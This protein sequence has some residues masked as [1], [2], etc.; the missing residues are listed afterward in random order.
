MMLDENAARQRAEDLRTQLHRHNHLYYVLDKPEITDAEYDVLLR[1][2]QQIEKNYPQLIVPD[3]P[4]QRVGGVPLS[5][6][7]SVVHQVPMLSLSNA[8]NADELRDFHRRVL[9]ITGTGTVEYVVELKIDGLAVSLEYLDGV[10]VRGATRGDGTVGEDI[11]TNLRTLPSVPLRLQLPLSLVARGEAYMP[12]ASFL[13][14]NQEREEAGLPV[15]ANPRNAAAGS[16]RQLDPR[17]TATR[18]LQVFL[19]NLATAEPDGRMTHEASLQLM[20]QAGLPVNNQRQSFTDIERLIDY[21]LSWH[22]RRHD[23]PYEIDGLVIKVNELSLH[24]RLGTTAKSPRWAIA[25]KFPAEQ[26]HT[27]LLDIEITVGRTGTLNPTA[28]LQ[29]VTIAGSVVSRASLH[30]ADLI[31]EKDIRIGDT[32]IVQKAGDVIPE[33]VGPVT[34]LRTGQEQPFQMPDRCPECGSEAVRYPG[35]VA[36]R[37]PNASCPALLRESLIHFASRDAMDI[38][39]LGPAMVNAL[40][41]ANLVRDVADLY[42]LTQDELLQ[43]ERVGAKSADNL[44][45][46]IAAS[47]QNSVERLVLGLGIRYVGA[48][49]AESLAKHFGSLPE[50]MMADEAS[51]LA[52][53]DVGGKVATSIISYFGAETNQ[54]LINK[55]AAAGV[56]LSYI[57]T[58]PVLDY[59]GGKTFVITGTLPT[60]SREEAGK[61]IERYGGRVSGSVSKK[62]DYLLAGEKAGSKLIK[63]QELKVPIISEEELLTMLK[64]QAG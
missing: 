10:L 29:P 51:L 17:V 12:K 31:A 58:E 48:K 15:F 59:L 7:A 28:L 23:L 11:T 36:W 39:G 57:G 24:D 38:E 3:S 44:K 14:L 37:C 54:K 26:V 52:V 61:L 19:Y 32:V 53:Q 42:Y 1:E 21:C 64:L 34:A 20:Q 4:T 30:N 35:E 47:K 9:E 46:A 45:K 63:A 8:Y 50:L 6:F 16:L 5:G 56:N 22:E 25:Y 13:R 60:M 40:L 55:L 33:V 27:R 2:L 43:L 49:V 62:T 18:G 41:E